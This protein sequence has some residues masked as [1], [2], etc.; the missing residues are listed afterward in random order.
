MGVA[1]KTKI[2]PCEVVMDTRQLMLAARLADTLHF[3]KTA[4]FENIAQSGLSAQIAKLESELGFKLFERTSHR[5]AL[6]QAGRNFIEQAKLLLN[7]M[8]STVQECRAIA[9]QSRGVLKVGFFGDAAGEL[10]HLIFSLFR[11]VNPDIRLIFTE[12]SMTNQ[13]Q[14][15]ISE[16]VD[17]ALIR[18]PIQDGRLEFDVMFDEPRVAAVPANHEMA[19]AQELRVSDLIEQPFAVAGD[20]AP[21]EWI[22]YWSLGTERAMP[23]RIGARV[24]SIP[25]SLAAIAYGGAFDT[26]PLTATRLFQH[27]G[28]RYVPLADAARSTLALVTLKGNRSPAVRTLRQ[29]VAKTL[30]QSLACLPQARICTQP[31]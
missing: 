13:V 9:E 28:V 25:E 5:V 3:G 11:R 16:K 7:S 17:A 27:P 29:C 14:S 15:L 12:L 24:Q 21:S 1:Y 31:Q 6:T 2:L 10:T 18:L 23:C 8:N 22:L 26:F 19:D 20:G 4:E 30:E